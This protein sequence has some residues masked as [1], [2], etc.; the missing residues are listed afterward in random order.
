[1][2]RRSPN[3]RTLAAGRPLCLTRFFFSL[4]ENGLSLFGIVMG[5]RHCIAGTSATVS[6]NIKPL[7]HLWIRLLR[8][9]IP[10]EKALWMFHRGWPPFHTAP[11]DHPEVR[12]PFRVP[13]EMCILTNPKASRARSGGVLRRGASNFWAPRRPLT[14]R[15]SEKMGRSPF[16]HCC[17]FL[18]RRR[19][20]AN[21]SRRQRVAA[22]SLSLDA[23]VECKNLVLSIALMRPV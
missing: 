2:K 19:F 15:A 7:Y 12:F 23:T 13:G 16:L 22:G 10:L 1:M 8:G 18:A 11:W 5:T 9:C 14:A 20:S 17:L 4:G 3:Q 6:Q 21:Q